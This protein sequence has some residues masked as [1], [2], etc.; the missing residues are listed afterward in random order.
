MAAHNALW[1]HMMLYGSTSCFM[2]AHHA[3]WQHMM[4]Y[5]ST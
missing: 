4:L 3:L 1:Q 5:G 2:A